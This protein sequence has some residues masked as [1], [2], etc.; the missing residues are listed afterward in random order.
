MRLLHLYETLDHVLQ[1]YCSQPRL[2][3]VSLSPVERARILR[4][5][6]RLQTYCNIFGTREWAESHG[7][8]RPTW[9]RHFTIDEM[10]SLFFRTMPP[11]E[12]EEFG[13]IWTFVRQ[14]YSDQFAAISRDFPRNSPEWRALRPATMPMDPSEL[15][16]SEDG[17]S[18]HPHPIP[19]DTNRAA[20]VEEE[21]N[22]NDDYDDYCNHLVALGPSFLSKVLRQPN[23]CARRRLLACNSV[24]AKSS[25]MDVVSVVTTHQPLLHPADQYEA[26]DIAS[27][28]ATLPETAQPAP[29]WKRHWYGHRPVDQ[30][31]YAVQD[32]TA[33]TPQEA[34]PPGEVSQR[35]IGF[36]P[37][38]T[39]GYAFWD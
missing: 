32:P 10:W 18:C 25:F 20:L 37:G 1:A 8:R 30:V 29:S 16:G 12:I 26:N 33:E 24:T 7:E 17:T 13:S 34:G 22:S 35:T 21:Y 9:H 15:Y 36:F 11:W 14:M 39:W 2:S 23:D 4:A 27:A 28:L 19:F 6:C 38:W 3:Q 31:M 5:L